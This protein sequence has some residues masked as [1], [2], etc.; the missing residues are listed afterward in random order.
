MRLELS[1]V[2]VRYGGIAALSEVSLTVRSA[3][4]AA[5]IGAN[6]AGKSTLLRA[7]MGLT[8]LASGRILVDDRPVDALATE[9]RVGLG[10]ALSPEGRRLF[11]EMSVHDNLRTGAYGRR[12]RGGIGADLARVYD[13]FPQIGRRRNSIAR[14]LS[15]GEQQMCAIGRALMARPR[16]LLLDEPSLGLAPAIVQDMARAIRAIAEEGVTVVLV[17]QNSRLALSLAGD[18]HVL[19]SGRLVRSA[20]A[21]ELL[22]DPELHRAYLGDDPRFLPAEE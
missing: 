15:G 2:S 13:L 10:M 7:V 3:S 22:A 9:A 19:A 4:V 16:L 1:G 8:A 14:T 12:D 20:P 11:G 5:I 17:E 21:A 18:G 6:G